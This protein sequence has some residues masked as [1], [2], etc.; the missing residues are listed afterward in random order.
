MG[1]L[2]IMLSGVALG[3]VKFDASVAGAMT[4]R[5]RADDRTRGLQG[6]VS[7]C[8]QRGTGVLL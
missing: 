7:F 8:A 6:S 4:E 2:F 1:I 5:V 3:W